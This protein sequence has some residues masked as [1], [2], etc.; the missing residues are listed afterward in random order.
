MTYWSYYGDSPCT[1][2]HF[3]G[4]PPGCPLRYGVGRVF[5][6]WPAT[7]AVIAEAAVL[8]WGGVQW[9]VACYETLYIRGC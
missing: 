9:R 4:K 7:T 1:V 3:W 8:L 5:M 2:L 6:S